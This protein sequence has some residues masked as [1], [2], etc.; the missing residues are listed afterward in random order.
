[1]EDEDMAS[2]EG[3]EVEIQALEEQ[4]ECAM[5]GKRKGKSK[6]AHARKQ[7]DSEAV[8]V[9]VDMVA[10]KANKRKRDALEREGTEDR[11]ETQRKRKRM[12]EKVTEAGE[13]GAQTNLKQRF[14]LFIGGS[15]DLSKN[16]IPHDMTRQ[17]E[18]F[19]VSRDNTRTLCCLW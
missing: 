18:I 17:P 16:P 6:G 10:G 14:I 3:G 13:N 4:D 19:N 15:L 7:R 12:D 2:S 1:M 8:A 9:A 5:V 11:N